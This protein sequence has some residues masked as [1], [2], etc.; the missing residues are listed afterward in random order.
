MSDQLVYVLN[1]HSIILVQAIVFYF[2]KTLRN[3]GIKMS[4]NE[5][6]REKEEKFAYFLSVKC[7]WLK[8]YLY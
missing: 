8:L 6:G 5:P 7:I 3:L 4:E 2:S 1:N